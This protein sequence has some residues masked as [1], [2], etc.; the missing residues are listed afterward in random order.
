MRKIKKGGG[1][2]PELP[3]TVVGAN[4][5]QEIVE[6]FRLVYSGLYNSFSTKAEMTTL[7]ILHE[8]VSKI[9]TPFSVHQVARITS[10]IVKKSVCTMKP[11]K[12]DVSSWYTSDF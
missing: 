11:R 9:I 7:P 1:G 8:K 5:E 3:D 12:S 2:P 6:K 10:S 4:G